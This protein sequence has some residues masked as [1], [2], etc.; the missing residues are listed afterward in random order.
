MLKTPTA[1]VR[2]S[3]EIYFRY[4]RDKAIG[5]CNGPEYMEKFGLSVQKALMACKAQKERKQK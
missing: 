1:V 3:K 5:G 2:Q 4:Q